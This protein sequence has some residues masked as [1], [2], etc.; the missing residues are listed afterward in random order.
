MAA[1]VDAVAPAVP[2]PAPAERPRRRGGRHLKALPAQRHRRSTAVPVLVGAGVVIS[3][4]FAVAVMHALLIG[5]QIRLDEMQ[6]DVASETEAVERLRLQV[7]EL[8]A[9]DRILDV[10]QERLGMQEPAE[11]GYVLPQGA[12]GADGELMSV[13]PA[14]VPPPPTTAAPAVGD[15]TSAEQ[16][17]VDAAVAAALASAGATPD[18]GDADPQA[19]ASTRAETGTDE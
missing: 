18:G 5:G 7:A 12:D 13:P 3:C 2:F 11:I 19:D 17:E 1:S 16:A 10:A 4:L 14:T 8:E 15:S 6:Q 9:P